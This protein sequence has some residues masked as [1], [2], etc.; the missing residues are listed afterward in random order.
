MPKTNFMGFD[1]ALAVQA[2]RVLAIETH[3]SADCLSLVYK[4]TQELLEEL[5]KCHPAN[6]LCLHSEP[7]S[8]CGFSGLSADV[9]IEAWAKKIVY[10]GTVITKEQA[11]AL[12]A[13]HLATYGKTEKKRGI[14]K[15]GYV[16]GIAVLRQRGPMAITRTRVGCKIPVDSDTLDKPSLIEGVKRY[17]RTF[18]PRLANLPIAWMS[19]QNQETIHAFICRQ[20]EETAKRQTDE[21]REQIIAQDS[22]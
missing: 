4:L 18:V 1:V 16:D 12:Y 9:Y 10:L 6:L 21:E 2:R 19:G 14:R 13:W 7:Y 5:A 22:W 20:A 3:S 8:Y 15:S 17:T 11:N